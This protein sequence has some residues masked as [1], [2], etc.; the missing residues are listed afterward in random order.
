MFMTQLDNDNQ[1]MLYILPI[2]LSSYVLDS[3]VGMTPTGISSRSL[4]S[5][6]YIPWDTV[7][8]C[9]IC[10]VVLTEL[11]LVTHREVDRKAYR[12]Q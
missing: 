6:N 2:F 4:A 8:V 12:E 11:Q 10:L 5:K 3:P 9:V 1:Y 7:A